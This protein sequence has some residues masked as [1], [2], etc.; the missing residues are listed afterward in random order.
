MNAPQHKHVAEL[1]TIR[2]IA[3]MI[4][5]I[6]HAISYYAT[7]PWFTLVKRLVNTQASVEIFFILS[8]FVLTASLSGKPFD[9]ASACAFYVKRLF[10]IYPALWAASTLALVYVLLL[11]FRIPVENSSPW[12]QARF[13]PDRLTPLHIAAS[14]AGFLAFLLPPVWTIFVELVGSLIMPVVAWLAM[15]KRR[16]FLSLTV[17]TAAASVILGGRLYYHLDL[18][19]F[20]FFLGAAIALPAPRLGAALRA[21]GAWRY[22]LAAGAAA[23]LIGLRAFLPVT[24]F[25]PW[26]QLAEALLAAGLLLLI[27]R[28]QAEMPLL[29]TKS[30]LWLGDIS[31]SLYLLHFPVMCILAKLF[32]FT[33]L[34]AIDPMALGLTLA[35]ATTVVALPMSSWVYFKVELPGIALGAR[36]LALLGFS[37][38]PAV[39]SLAKSAPAEA[40]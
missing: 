7:P 1:Q 12:F 6:G 14:Y 19:V 36:A 17:L 38:P 24:T 23:L 18:Y 30:M 40:I 27:V 31:Y 22:A 26:M 5:V 28:G 2:G 4:V 35:A 25:G 9:R 34:A 13:R 16:V 3:A 33:P 21:L 20:D 10:R 8:G 37:R 11:H 39:S 29:K 32:T 15:R